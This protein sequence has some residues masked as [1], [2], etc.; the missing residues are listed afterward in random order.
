MLSPLLAL[1]PS[2]T[3]FAQRYRHRFA[4]GT[5]RRDSASRLTRGVSPPSAAYS[6][7][8]AASR[9][10]ARSMY[11]RP[12]TILSVANGVDHRIAKLCLDAACLRAASDVLHGDD[13]T[14]TYVDQFLRDVRDVVEHVQPVLVVATQRLPPL[15]LTP[16][17]GRTLNRP[18]AD[19]RVP[20]LRHGVQAAICKRLDPS[21]HD[22]NILL[23][24][25]LLP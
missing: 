17:V 19:L 20:K 2:H 6:R 14:I 15:H 11:S 4:G 1:E 9:A 13:A 10:S 7:S 3:R 12:R 21:A 8:P 16:I 25:L 24:H 5:L 18:P 23:R 22:L